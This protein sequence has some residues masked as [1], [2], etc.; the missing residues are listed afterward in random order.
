MGP[1]VIAVS[2]ISPFIKFKNSSKETID[3]S[4]ELVE[5]IRRALIQAG[6]KLSK[7]IKHENKAYD[8]EQRLKHI[9]QFCP[10]LVDKLCSITK[11]SGARK[12]RAEEG[13]IKILGRDTKTSEQ[14]LKKATTQLDKAVEKGDIQQKQ[15]INEDD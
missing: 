11:S 9:E 13:I 3:S 6:Q 15:E 7:H 2:V 14:E 8:L 1:Y 10:I 4:D 5:E 12:K